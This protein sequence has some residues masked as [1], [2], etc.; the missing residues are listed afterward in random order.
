MTDQAAEITP[1]ST[2]GA[3]PVETAYEL[4]NPETI[5]E[6]NYV[7][8]KLPSDNMRVFKMN[9]GS[10]V[11]LGKFGSFRVNDIIGHPFGYTYEIIGEKQLRVVAEEFTRDESDPA[12]V[13]ELQPDE[14]NRELYDDP[15]AQQL[16][17]DE[18]EELKKRSADGGRELI[19]RVISSHSAW[20]KKTTFSQ[21]KYIKRKEQKFLKRFTP[22]PIG[23]SELVDFYLMKEAHKVLDISEESLGLMLS[24]ANIRPGG[25]YLV[26][27]DMSGIL[28]AALLER[29]GGDGVIVVAHDSEHPNLDCLKYMNLSEEYIDEH[30]KSINWLDFFEPEQADEFTEKTPEEL[31]SMRSHQRGQYYRK[32]RRADNYNE[33]R[34]LIDH[35]KFDALIVGTELY[36]PTL[37]SRLVPAVSGSRP[38]V[39][40][41]AAKEA[42]VETTHVLHRD[43]R[44]LAPTIMETRVRRYQTLPGRLHPHMTMRGGGGYVLSGTRVI[45]SENVNAVGVA[46]GKKRKAEGDDG[47]DGKR[48]EGTNPDTNPDTTMDT[49]V[50]MDLNTNNNT[51]TIPEPSVQA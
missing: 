15:S 32:K 42:L 26:V 35:G 24:L 7:M 17:M 49:T 36:V 18:I 38:I 12:V 5:K 11:H 6:G 14:N 31:K 27:D 33:V 21:E 43:L 1:P 28:V 20:E 29:M 13:D 50:D 41:D 10:T 40:Y 48:V 34:T 4:Y 3:K 44:V 30:V 39:V 46:R 47:R 2:A 9:A 51:N 25:R 8:I 19:D 22:V 45:P 23:S 37:I 16:T